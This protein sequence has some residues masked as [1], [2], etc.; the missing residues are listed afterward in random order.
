MVVGGGKVSFVVWIFV[1]V[2]WVIFFIEINFYNKL[3]MTT[4]RIAYISSQ[5]LR[6]QCDRIEVIKN[7]VSERQKL[8]DWFFF[9]VDLWTV[10][11]T[12]EFFALSNTVS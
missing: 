4:T 7:R 11:L 8:V 5:E 10:F 1:P 12:K 2:F 6:A 9:I 3:K